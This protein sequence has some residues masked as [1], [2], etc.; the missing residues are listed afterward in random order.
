MRETIF[1]FAQENE[2]NHATLALLLID[3]GVDSRVLE[4][5]YK[6]EKPSNLGLKR[7]LDRFRREID[8]FFRSTK[9][10]A[11]FLI[12]SFQIACEFAGAVGIRASEDAA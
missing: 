9:M 6:S 4:Y 8:L 12:V 11:D 2:V 3:L 10:D 7:D 5:L 1:A